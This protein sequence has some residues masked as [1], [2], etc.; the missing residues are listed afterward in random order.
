M[1]STSLAVLA[2]A[3]VPSLAPAAAKGVRVRPVPLGTADQD[4]LQ[5]ISGYSSKVRL[6]GGGILS[7]LHGGSSGLR[8]LVEVR[9]MQALEEA[10]TGVIPFSGIQARGNS[11]LFSAS[12]VS[13]TVE[14]LTPDLFAKQLASVVSA[15]KIAFAHEALSYDP[16]TERLV[17]PLGAASA[18]TLK[19]VYAGSGIPAAFRTLLC[20]WIEADELSLALGPS[21]VKLKKRVLGVRGN[22]AGL[23]LP[24]VAALVEQLTSLADALS[25]EKIESLLRSPLVSTA[26]SRILGVDIQTVVDQFAALR[27]EVSAGDGD[28][29]AWLAS[30]LSQQLTDSTLPDWLS[31]LDPVRAYRA[32]AALAEARQIAER[33]SL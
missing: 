28:A 23:A 6:V 32:R 11:L 3:F 13:F 8:I 19:L 12:G 5:W 7:R 29:V 27:G 33:R 9:D 10:L 15:K 24:V 30:L 16:A 26:V 14:N 1:R 17:D 2:V 22:R 4:V 20:A 18:A 31:S 21:F 25:T